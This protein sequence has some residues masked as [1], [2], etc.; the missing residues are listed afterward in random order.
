MGEIEALQE[1]IAFQE[2]A[3]EELTRGLL[4]Q[5]ERLRALERELERLAL[6]ARELERRLPDAGMPHE[7]PP[8]Y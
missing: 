7:P 6:L 3:I 8:H 4:R 5:E 1:R 2:A